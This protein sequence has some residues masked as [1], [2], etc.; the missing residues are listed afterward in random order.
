MHTSR[1]VLTHDYMGAAPAS[2]EENG[3]DQDSIGLLWIRP[4]NQDPRKTAFAGA[5]FIDGPSWVELEKVYHFSSAGIRGDR[6]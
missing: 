1:T 2:Q 4:I 5:F 6:Q 3:P